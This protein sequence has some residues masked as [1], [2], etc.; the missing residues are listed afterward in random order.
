VSRPAAL[1]LS[2]GRGRLWAALR[3]GGRIVALDLEDPRATLG[4]GRIVRGR[5]SR[6]LHGVQAAFVDL[7]RDASGF[8][9]TREILKPGH[10]LAVQVRRGPR[11]GKVA[12]LTTRIQLAGRYL[13]LDA[14]RAR[15]AISRR[16]RDPGVRERLRAL[17]DSLAAPP[18]A[19]WI[20]RAAAA[21]AHVDHV[22]DEATRLAERWRAIAVRAGEPGPPALLESEPDLVERA[23]R[24]APGADE[25]E[26]IL[27]DDLE[28]RSIVLDRL[29][30]TAPDLIGR[31][32]LVSGAGTLFDEE[33][34]GAVAEAL[35]PR[36][37]LPSGGTLTIEETAAL[38]SIDVDGGS[39][40]WESANREAAREI[41]RQL[42]LRD[43]GGAIVVDWISPSDPLALRG[44]VDACAEE[45]A[46][47]PARTRIV[48]LSEIGLL[49]LTRE[50]LGP[51]LAE[52][53]ER[54][55]P[56]CGGRGRVSN[57]QA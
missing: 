18:G 21:T 7:D 11:A 12:E 42:R 28:L 27:L 20:V 23:L 29:A 9:P 25:L 44:V 54:D 55:C 56:T 45:L 46:R 51:G 38:V 16:V 15:R 4:R 19:G 39:D 1:L 57:P 35:A 2:R 47:D 50:R 33:I 14:T 40:A 5:V 6:V 8:L 36:V 22:R 53:L 13:V 34:G 30:V 48:G 3:E 32:R 31:T 49:E 24:D 52:L 37:A 43:L 17:V 26:E 41:P 10:E